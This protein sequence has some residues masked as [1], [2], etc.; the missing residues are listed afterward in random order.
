MH[1]REVHAMVPFE[2]L[3]IRHLVPFVVRP[4]TSRIIKDSGSS[5]QSHHLLKKILPKDSHPFRGFPYLPLR[6]ATGSASRSEQIGSQQI[7]EQLAP[8]RHDFVI[9]VSWARCE[10]QPPSHLLAGTKET[11]K[12]LPLLATKAGPRDKALWEK[13][14]KEELQAL[15]KYFFLVCH[16]ILIPRDPI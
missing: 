10:H 3:L 8:F 16:C 11:V 14:L 1:L 15:I 5:R 6:P 12:K 2:F 7:E 9:N 4:L 13:R